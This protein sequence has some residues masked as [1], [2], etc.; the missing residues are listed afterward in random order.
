MSA[1]ILSNPL[2]NDKAVM[3]PL[4]VIIQRILKGAR[5]SQHS[6]W[7]PHVQLLLGRTVRLLFLVH[8][9]YMGFAMQPSW[10]LLSDTAPLPAFAC[11][12][13][14]YEE[15]PDADAAAAEAARRTS[16]LQSAGRS[17]QTLKVC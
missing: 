14:T 9:G 16:M 5:P 17:P 15:V 13:L 4:L 10:Q 3:Q 11:R 1:S 7:I 8:P 6:G 12:S 2:D